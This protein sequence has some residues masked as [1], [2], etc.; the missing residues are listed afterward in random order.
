VANT[1]PEYG[2]IRWKV[3]TVRFPESLYD[4]VT[5]EAAERDRSVSEYIREIGRDRGNTPANTDGD[6][7]RDRVATLEARVDALEGEAE[8]TG[9]TA[10]AQE[11]ASDSTGA[12]GETSGDRPGYFKSIKGSLGAMLCSFW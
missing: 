12:A 2:R 8:T 4:D 10:T 7:L 9:A 6:G 5:A 11:A 3:T 1:R